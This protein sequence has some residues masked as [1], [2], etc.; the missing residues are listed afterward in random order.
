MLAICNELWKPIKGYEGLYEVSTFGRVKS[1]D[2]N[3]TGKEKIMSP[4][5]DK[6]GYQKIILYRKGKR[7]YYRI[8]RLVAEAWLKPVS[9]KNIINH[10]DECPRNNH[11]SNLEWCNIKY[12]NTYGTR[13]E[14]LSKTKTN[15]KKSKIVYQY[16]LDG[17]FIKEWPS[18]HE[19]ERQLGYPPANI[20]ACCKRKKHCNTSHGFKWSYEKPQDL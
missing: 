16:T 1:L 5:K 7:G 13:L 10:K 2:Y 19:I 11:Y 4:V 12:N 18:L 17:E 14:R 8:H 15:G 3:G 9:E 6:N 20:S